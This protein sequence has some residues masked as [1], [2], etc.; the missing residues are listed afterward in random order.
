[1]SAFDTV[2]V[3]LSTGLSR[4]QPAGIDIVPVSSCQRLSWGL[5]LLLTSKLLEGP[6]GLQ[7]PPYQ[8]MPFDVNLGLEHSQVCLQ[9]TSRGA[10]HL[11]PE[12]PG[13]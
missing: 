7:H 11:S 6:D 5:D 10:S 8:I 4:L 9:S 12:E 1:M 3:L 13:F 2:F